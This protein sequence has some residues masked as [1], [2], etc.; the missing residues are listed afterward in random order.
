MSIMEGGQEVLE[1]RKLIKM[2]TL[3]SRRVEY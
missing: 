2:S 1:Q 3:A